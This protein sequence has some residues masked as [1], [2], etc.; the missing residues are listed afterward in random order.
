MGSAFGETTC[1]E[2]GCGSVSYVA[3]CA[4]CATRVAIGL[5]LFELGVVACE[6]LAFDF[7]DFRESAS[8]SIGGGVFCG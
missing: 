1:D 2:V 4:V 6:G 8:M 7:F 3:F 5:G